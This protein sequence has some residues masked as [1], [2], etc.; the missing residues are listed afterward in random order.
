MLSLPPSLVR[1]TFPLGREDDGRNRGERPRLP[2][3]PAAR[4]A[5]ISNAPAGGW[6][7]LHRS[8][9]AWSLGRID[10]HRDGELVV[11]LRSSTSA[12]LSAF[13]GLLRGFLE[14]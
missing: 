12:I 6:G 14:T 13:S 9:A 2:E 7:K 5:M 1:A 4:E 8:P 3:L 11:I 10:P